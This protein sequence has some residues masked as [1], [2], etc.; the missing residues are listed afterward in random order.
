MAGVTRVVGR[1]LLAAIFI[2]SGIMSFQVSKHA[3]AA[4]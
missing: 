3:I 1:L 4:V 2:L